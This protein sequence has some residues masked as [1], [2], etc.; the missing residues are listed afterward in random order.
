MKRFT[1]VHDIL[2]GPGLTQAVAD[3][4]AYA[5][6]PWKDEA[7]G[8]HKTV[9]LLFMNPSLRTRMSTQKAAT[10]LGAET[11]VLNGRLR[12]AMGL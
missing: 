8:K 7:L 11:I 2:K 5:S 10:L 9:G 6:S 1:S 3:A 4:L 12:H